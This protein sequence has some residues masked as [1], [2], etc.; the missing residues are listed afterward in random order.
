MVELFVGKPN[1]ENA[2]KKNPRHKQQTAFEGWWWPVRDEVFDNKLEAIHAFMA[3]WFGAHTTEGR[4]ERGVL[5][6]DTLNRVDIFLQHQDLNVSIEFSFE[7]S[8]PNIVNE[9]DY[10]STW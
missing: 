4:M 8:C 7:H 2:I 9:S 6:N 5:Y 10:F 1:S 3:A